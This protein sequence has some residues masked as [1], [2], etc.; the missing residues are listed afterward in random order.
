M[1]YEINC[2]NCGDKYAISIVK[3]VPKFCTKCGGALPKI[4]TEARISAEAVMA[5][6]PDLKDRMEAAWDAYFVLKVEYDNEVRKLRDYKLRGTI[7]AEELEPY[8]TRKQKITSQT[9]AL[10]EYRA[11]IRA[12]KASGHTE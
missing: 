4:K 12:K 10:K 1:K 11:S 7:T 8:M 9:E 2:P 5:K 3:S 6:L